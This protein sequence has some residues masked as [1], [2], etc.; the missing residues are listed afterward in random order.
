MNRDLVDGRA[1]QAVSSG[2]ISLL[3][4][5]RGASRVRRHGPVAV[6]G[7]W[8]NLRANRLDL[9]QGMIMVFHIYG[10]IGGI[11]GRTH[12][13]LCLILTPNFAE[14]STSACVEDRGKGIAP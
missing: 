12:W 14:P 5:K 3:R 4:I 10:K 2:V 11:G 13:E 8:F 7:E 6:C 9:A 1:S